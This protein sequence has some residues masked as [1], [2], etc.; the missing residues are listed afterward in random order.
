MMQTLGLEEMI[1]FGPQ[2]FW[3]SHIYPPLL[4]MIRYVFTFPE[5]N[6]GEPVSAMAVDF[7]LYALYAIVYG[8]VNALLFV[9]TRSLTKN[10]WVALGVTVVWAIHPGYITTM[11]LLESSPLS[12]LTISLTLFSLYMFLR[13]RNLMWS[14]AFFA[15]LFLASLART[16]TQIHVLAFL[17]IALIS[18][19]FISQKRSWWFFGVNI[20]IIAL[21]FALP[22]KMKVMYDTWDVTT[23]AGYHRA[24]LLW[25]DP[26]T[27]PEP[28]Y[29]QEIVDNAL[30]FS[31]RFNTQETLKDNYRLSAAAN[32]FLFSHPTEAVRN[33]AKSLTITVPEILRPS[34]KYTQN[35][36]VEKIPWR[37]AWDWLFSG[38]PY[39]LLI[40]A[41]AFMIGVAAVCVG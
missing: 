23:F 19:W 22:I 16:V 37:D 10:N 1:P 7:R 33:L 18:F 6:S 2:S 41:S 36:M 21:T 12:M 5:T 30:A 14:S 26:R 3:Y 25:I 35:Y 9:W 39:L 24:G 40:C 34:S 31:T 13:Y 29:P 27:V 8:L 17:L 32:Q 11:T 20:L 15:S 38:I 28:E 4:D